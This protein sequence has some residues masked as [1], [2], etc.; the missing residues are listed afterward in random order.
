MLLIVSITLLTLI[1]LIGIYESNWLDK[2]YR[3]GTQWLLGRPWSS[4]GLLNDT[5][6]SHRPDHR[7]LERTRM[8]GRDLMIVN[9]SETSRKNLQFLSEFFFI[10]QILQLEAINETT[11]VSSSLD[12]TIAVWSAVDGK[13]K[14]HMK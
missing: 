1:P 12:Q 5:R 3:G 4:V 13:L 2:M 9:N 11:I 10:L 7:V 6:Y 8:R 14:F